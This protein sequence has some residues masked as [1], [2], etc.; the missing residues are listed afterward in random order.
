LQA[1]DINY[2]GRQLV[3][4]GKKQKGTSSSVANS[5]WSHSRTCRHGKGWTIVVEDL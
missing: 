3:V 5:K 1:I 4:D 2:E